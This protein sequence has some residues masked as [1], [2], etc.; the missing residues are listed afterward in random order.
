MPGK[1]LHRLWIKPGIYQAANERSPKRVY[2]DRTVAD[3]V[4]FIFWDSRAVK[5]T[6]ERLQQAVVIWA[7]ISVTE[8]VSAD[9]GLGCPADPLKLL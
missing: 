8:D 7:P 9:D 6:V 3:V 5:A 1:D 4:A 2:I